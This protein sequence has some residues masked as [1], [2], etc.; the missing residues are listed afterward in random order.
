MGSGGET[1]VSLK[2]IAKECGVS[3]STVSKALNDLSDVSEER[4]RTIR[5]K[6]EEMGYFPNLV[7][8]ALKTNTTYNIGVLFVD[9][10]NSGLTHPYFARV[11]ESLK[12]EAENYGYDITFIN[13]KLGKQKMSYYEHCIYRNVDGVV[14]ACVDFL[15]PEVVELVNGNIPVVTIDHIFNGVA[16]IVSDNVKGM[17]ELMEYVIENGHRKI[18]YIYGKDS[19][20]TQARLASFYRTLERHGIDVP[21]EYVL[22][23]RYQ[24]TQLTQDLTKKLLALKDRPTCI[25]F[26][27]DYASIG[28]INAIKEAGLSIPQDISVVGFDGI[29]ISQVLSPKLTTYAQNTKQIGKEAARQLIE[30]IEK[31]KTTLKEITVISGEVVEGKSINNIIKG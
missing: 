24:D 4:K 14:V 23:A 25:A 27:D 8:R 5:E 1:M 22:E 30:I 29:P 26:P 28:G 2:D 19:C 12:A 18:A 9:E 15:D 17:Q 7:A 20:V 21:E 11:L 31:P 10:N 16:A 3:V 13:T 6:A